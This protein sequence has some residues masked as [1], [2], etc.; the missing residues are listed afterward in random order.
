MATN[1]IVTIKFRVTVNAGTPS[2]TVISN[3]GSVDSDQTVPKPT[4]ADGIDAN[5]DQPTDI[6]VGGPSTPA[7]A[8]YAEKYV[9]LQVDADASGTVTQ[10][11]TLRYTIILHNTGA[12]SL[13]NVAFSDV[14]PGGLT[15]IPASAS[16]AVGA[17]A[18]VGASVTWSSIGTL[19]PGAVASA[20][21]DVTITSVTPPSQTYVN[22]GTAT[23]TQT[24]N[25][26]DG[27]QRQSERRQP[28]D[29]DHRGHRRRRRIAALDVQ[30]RWVDRHRHAAAP[31]SSSPGDTLLYTITVA[32]NGAASATNVHLTDPVPTCTGAL[33]P[34]TIATS[35]DRW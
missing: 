27:W 28:A 5:G 3:Q 7:S 12:A 2:G 21:F 34:C 15:Y 26:Q 4:D 17:I 25:V 6:V 8:L 33:N 22:Q 13:T 29:D 9:A 32:N 1:D 23:S 20:T 11:D 18:V 30:K 16:T 24:G 31:A 19:A 35:P 14:I 10:G